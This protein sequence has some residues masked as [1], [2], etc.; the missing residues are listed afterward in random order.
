MWLCALYFVLPILWLVIASTKN[1]A[2]L[3][4]SF[5]F[6]FGSRF[7]LFSNLADVFSAQN[8][9]F[10]QWAVNTVF[11]AVVSGSV[12]ESIVA[13]L[14]TI[15]AANATLAAYHTGRRAAIATV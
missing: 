10:L 1:N 4:T 11:Y 5:G 13:Q 15:L 8:G 7:S 6:A 9:I 3:F 2:D 14:G 12:L